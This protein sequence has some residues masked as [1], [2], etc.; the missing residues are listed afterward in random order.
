M[1]KII[2]TV[3]ISASLLSVSAF[4][5]TKYWGMGKNIDE[6][7]KECEKSNLVKK[8]DYSLSVYWDKNKKH[9]VC[10]FEKK[11]ES[12]DDRENNQGKRKYVEYNVVVEDCIKGKGNPP[13]S[14]EKVIQQ[15]NMKYKGTVDENTFSM[16]D[17]SGEQHG[18][19][20]D[21]LGNTYMNL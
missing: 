19:R 15:V 7:R 13:P 12:N 1:R 2:S 6:A 18:C 21:V 17:W 10:K 4:A 8:Q 3:L 20:R 11:N 5:D 9:A 14:K 16:T